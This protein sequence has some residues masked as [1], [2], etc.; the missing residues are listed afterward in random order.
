MKC[1]PRVV[2]GLHPVHEYLRAQ[3]DTIAELYVIPSPK[4][5]RLVEE[6]RRAGIPVCYESQS[7]L[8]THTQ[9]GTHQGIAVRVR[10]F[11]YLLF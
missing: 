7:A 9:G 1:K 8:D 2:Y 4:T 6:A 10:Q 5:A 11:S 3:P